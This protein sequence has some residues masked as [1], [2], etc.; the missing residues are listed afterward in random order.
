M[1]L[2]S[3]PVS[4]ESKGGWV[5]VGDGDGVGEGGGVVGS[6]VGVGLIASVGGGR[7]GRG[8]ATVATGAAGDGVGAGDDVGAGDGCDEPTVADVGDRV[9]AARAVTCVAGGGGVD[10]AG[11]AVGV[12]AGESDSPQPAM[13]MV[14]PADR[15]SARRRREMRAELRMR[16][17]RLS[18]CRLDIATGCGGDGDGATNVLLASRLTGVQACRRK[19]DWLKSSA[20]PMSPGWLGL[21]EDTAAGGGHAGSAFGDG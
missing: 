9:D 13:R 8:A 11:A 1:A 21:A 4:G 12:G 20:C 17:V 6:G 18:G 16:D 5:G 10:A 7:V 15:N 14:V 2:I 19:L 3:R